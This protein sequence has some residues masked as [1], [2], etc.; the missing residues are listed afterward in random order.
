MNN[1]QLTGLAHL[2]HR[3]WEPHCNFK[4]RETRLAFIL[5]PTEV[6]NVCSRALWTRANER[7]PVRRVLCWLYAT[8]FVTRAMQLPPKAFSFSY[9]SRLISC[10]T[11]QSSNCAYYIYLSWKH[12]FLKTGE[13][14]ATSIHWCSWG[15]WPTPW[16]KQKVICS[17]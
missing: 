8:P 10:S 1:R 6:H 7:S 13:S 4:F 11:F 16:S 3:A 2:V 14:E 12:T 5:P 9:A 15:P 17:S